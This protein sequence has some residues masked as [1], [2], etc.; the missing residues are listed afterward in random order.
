MKLVASTL[1]LT[2][3]AC[4]SSGSSGP[5]GGLHADGGA[6]GDGG[7]LP[8]G[9]TPDGA[10]AP[11]RTVFVIPMENEPSSK[12]YGNTTDA[13]YLNGLMTGAT[14]RA[15]YGT[16][17]QDPLATSLPSEPHYVFMEGGTNVFSDHTFSTDAAPSASNSTSST[18]HLV[19]AL[20]AAHVPWMSYQ[21]GIAANTCPI[22][23]HGVY[24]PKHDP[25]I[26]FQDV[27]G[28]PPTGSAARCV[29]HHKPYTSL[30]A[31]LAAGITGYVFI[32][33]D[34]CHDMHGDAQCAQGT[35]VA[36][37][38]K[39]GDTW[40]SQELPALIAFTK[41][42]DAVIFIVW[43]EGDATSGLISFLALGANAK[44]GT[45]V[46]TAYNHGSL[47]KSVAEYLG[48]AVPA[49][50]A[51]TNDFAAMFQPGTFP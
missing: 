35:G 1:A 8:D 30:A 31:D 33:P 41:T 25:F 22:A 36:P 17:F 40:L 43:D 32:T 21:Q 12:I 10:A 38:I 11:P 6:A 2:L 15:S 28:S 48:A 44:A 3:A 4:G 9:G 23:A 19:N 26:F 29:A 45:A 37:N 51:P 47:I 42:H 50:A 5:D 39:A 34:L 20:E 49:A 14:P 46:S 18:A 13:P 16:M 7:G 24:A 27:A